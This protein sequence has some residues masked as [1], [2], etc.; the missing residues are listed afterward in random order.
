MEER[1]R[2]LSE[3]RGEPLTDSDLSFMLEHI[4]DERG[5][6]RD[7]L[8][9]RMFCVGCE[10]E[11]FSIE[12]F[13]ET[14]RFL[15]EG[16]FLFRRGEGI[17]SILERSFSAL[18]LTLL[19]Y[20]DDKG[21]SLYYRALSEEQRA[22]LVADA[23]HFF[24][25]EEDSTG[26]TEANG[27][28]H[29]MAHASELLLG[30]ARHSV[31]DRHTAE[32]ML[33]AVFTALV[34]REALFTDGDEKRIALIPLT[35]LFRKLVKPEEIV[36]WIRRFAKYYEQSSGAIG[37]IRSRG[38]VLNLLSFMS[39]FPEVRGSEAILKEISRFHCVEEYRSYIGAEEES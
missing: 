32:L 36:A 10:E 22:R 16:A 39:I 11:L 3:N 25:S 9:Y 33:E 35:L 18:T 38:N 24:E 2:S 26:Y 5:E 8:I 31:C 27:W 6:V 12:Q 37:S 4:G 34:K 30:I 23:I 21:D 13:R 15:S 1:M 19:L 14:Y 28:V 7:G 29:T 17:R 20:F